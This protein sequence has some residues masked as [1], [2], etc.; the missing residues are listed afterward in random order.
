MPQLF[1]SKK[2]EGGPIER[3]DN[4]RVTSGRPQ[5]V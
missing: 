2:Q 4:T 5:K 3:A 1:A